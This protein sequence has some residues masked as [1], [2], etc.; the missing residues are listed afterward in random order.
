MAM[1][2]ALN[3]RRGGRSRF[4]WNERHELLAEPGFEGYNYHML[5]TVRQA[6]DQI[7]VTHQ[8]LRYAIYRGK[9]RRHE[10]YGRILVDSAEVAHFQQ[11]RTHSAPQ[12]A[13]TLPTSHRAATWQELLKSFDADDEAEQR[14]TF[15]ALQ[16]AIDQDRPGQRSIF[17]TGFNPSAHPDNK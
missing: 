12:L 17:G 2:K 8:T 4:P 1:T 16:T 5:L 13:K 7:G 14:R 3:Q 9:L 10:R 15:E 6:A 11:A